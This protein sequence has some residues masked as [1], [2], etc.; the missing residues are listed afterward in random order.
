MVHL[1]EQLLYCFG[2]PTWY[3]MS[4]VE[5]AQR[6]ACLDEF[7]IRHERGQVQSDG[8]ACLL[9]NTAP[10]PLHDVRAGDV[11]IYCHG[12]QPYHAITY[13]NP[14]EAMLVDSGHHHGTIKY[15]LVHTDTWRH[16]IIQVR[17][18]ERSLLR[19]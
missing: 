13:L 7:I 11:L 3:E 16:G 6:L 4:C 1:W 14:L 12:S 19:P 10:V 17:R 9:W 8:W 18:P 15:R 5:M 2:G